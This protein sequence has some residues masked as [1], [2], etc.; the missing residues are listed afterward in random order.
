MTENKLNLEEIGALISAANAG[1]SAMGLNVF[2]NNNGAVMQTA[3]NKLQ[4]QQ[5]SIIEGLQA[6]QEESSD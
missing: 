6:D 5:Q 4:G 1:V 2:A 3:L